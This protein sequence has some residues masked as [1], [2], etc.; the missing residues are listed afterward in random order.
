MTREQLRKGQVKEA[1][2]NAGTRDGCRSWA[3]IAC[4]ILIVSFAEEAVV[5]LIS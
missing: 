4:P 1:L 5:G 2:P 3:K